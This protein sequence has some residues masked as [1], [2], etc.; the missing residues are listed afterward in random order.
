MNNAT[1]IIQWNYHGIRQKIGE[2]V[3]FLNTLKVLPDIILIQETFLKN[4]NPFKLPGYQV[5][6]LDRKESTSGG[7][8]MNCIRESVSFCSSAVLEDP[9]CLMTT[10]L[11]KSCKLQI[12]NF[13]A[14]P[15]RNFY[16]SKIKIIELEKILSHRDS[17]I[18]G[19]INAY[20]PNFGAQY[21]DSRD[22]IVEDIILTNDL[23]SLNTAK[24][25]HLTQSGN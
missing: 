25:T 16:Y 6:R 11:L 2:L 23:V 19:D 17:L 3:S 15:K 22:K 21:L 12:I 8:V 4:R 24:G 10:I 7:G 9:E 13:Y 14:S 20:S 1:N 18:C 5:E